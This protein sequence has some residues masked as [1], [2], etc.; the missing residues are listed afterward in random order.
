MS[1][2]PAPSGLSNLSEGTERFLARLVDAAL[3]R[4]WRTP[5]DFLL[6][7]PPGDLLDALEGEPDV[8]QRLLVEAA[9][10][11][12]K[13]A[14]RHSRAAAHEDLEIALD[15][16][17]AEPSRILELLPLD[18][19]IR[20]LDQATL[21]S[22]ALDGDWLERATQ[23][24]GS[25]TQAA[26][27]VTFVLGTALAERLISMRDLASAIPLEQ[28]AARASQGSLRKIFV[29]ALHCAQQHNVP[30]E[31]RLLEM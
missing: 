23:D 20:L 7:F 21:W 13:L 16:G 24:R 25:L 6:Y 11:P 15:E 10:I 31:A 26:E 28:L 3:E 4:N 2:D 1:S 18:V 14:S 19:R 5:E 29:Y 9:G 8:R 27:R 22:F 30:D 12:A 17:L